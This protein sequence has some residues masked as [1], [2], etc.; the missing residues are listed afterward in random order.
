MESQA[1][2]GA[3][4]VCGKVWCRSSKTWEILD[5]TYTH[6][7]V[8]HGAESTAVEQVLGIHNHGTLQ[9][10]LDLVEVKASELR[11]AGADHQGVD[12]F[13][14]SVRCLAVFDGAIELELCFG[15]R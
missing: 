13:R 5:S 9:K 6:V 15:D 3:Q 7:L 14:G 2:S 4:A 11:P 10:V 1:E 12:S 8:P